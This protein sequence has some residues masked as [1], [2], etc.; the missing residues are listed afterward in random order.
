MN[1]LGMILFEQSF[2]KT[3]RDENGT[4]CTNSKTY[5]EFGIFGVVVELME[6]DIGAK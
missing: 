1:F 3:N 6:T 5:P 2:P 4:G